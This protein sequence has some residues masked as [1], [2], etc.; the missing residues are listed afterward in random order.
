MPEPGAAPNGSGAG[1]VIE[2]VK[3]MISSGELRAG[4]RLPIEKELTARWGVSRGSLR[5]AVRALAALGILETRQG[6][7]T[8]VTQLD[9][10]VMLAPLGFCAGLQG[11]ARVVELLAL[12]HTL[13]TES[14]A[15]AAA[16]ISDEQLDRL[17][18]ILAQLDSQ[19]AT[20]HVDPERFLDADTDFHRSIAVASGN[21][22][23]AAVVDSLMT[24][25]VRARLWRALTER[26]SV[27]EAHAEHRAVLA[28]L[29]ARDPQ[30]ASIRMAS[31]L[32]GVEEYAA[33]HPAEMSA[34]DRDA[35]PSVDSA[36][37]DAQ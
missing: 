31:H 2:K 16:R 11:H 29:L 21:R 33:A 14:A 35:E 10:A 9:P 12:R 23:L 18:A 22:A 36:P 3:R 8:Y 20:G 32:L 19:F 34:V 15:L 37:T 4:D 27:A 28:A 26:D 6:D 30:R 17:E 5:E 7:G 24:R 13:E 1:L 25:T